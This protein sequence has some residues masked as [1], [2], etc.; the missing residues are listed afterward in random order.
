MTHAELV[1]VALSIHAPL[2]LAAVAA[3]FKY[4]DRTEL[5]SKSLQ[6]TDAVLS[7]MR[8]EIANELGDGLKPIFENP[9]T[10]PTMVG[11]DTYIERPVNPIG[12]EPYRSTIRDFVED[13]ANTLVNCRSLRAARDAW[14]FWARVLS[15]SILGLL[16]WQAVVTGSLAL[17]DK[18][19]EITIADHLIKLSAI[20][21]T[22]GV[23]TSLTPLPFLLKWHD[24]INNHRMRYDAP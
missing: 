7:R 9:G 11:T 2:L 17:F 13:N 1:N 10:V 21:T 15:W 5:L 3:Y 6:G 19:L 16:L 8:R 24:V 18:V 23:I 12:S 20:P 4:G 22:V 14:C